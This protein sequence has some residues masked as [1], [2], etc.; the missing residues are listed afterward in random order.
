MMLIS[1]GFIAKACILG[2][3]VGWLVELPKQHSNSRQARMQ[4]LLADIDPKHQS[5]SAARVSAENEL[6]SVASLS[7]SKEATDLYQ[8]ILKVNPNSARVHFLLAKLQL[9]NWYYNARNLPQG[10]AI[11]LSGLKHLETA[12]Y[13]YQRQGDAVAA[14]KLEKVHGEVDKGTNPIN[15]VFPE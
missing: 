12:T 13:L 9:F 6:L 15:W 3:L 4:Y 1:R 8:Q 11:K 7:P 2:L 14:A 10:D 5:S